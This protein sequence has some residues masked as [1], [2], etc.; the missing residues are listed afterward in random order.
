MERMQELGASITG[1]KKTIAK[2]A[3]RK[4]LQGNRNKQRK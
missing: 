4:G 2:W 3:K 1:I